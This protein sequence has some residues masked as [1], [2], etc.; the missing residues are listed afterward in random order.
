[1]PIRMVDDPQNPKRRQ[2]S[3]SRKSGG[4][5]RI[6][7]LLI[8]QLL[9]FLIKKPKLLIG[10]IVIGGALYF[11][12][13]I[14]KGGGNIAVGPDEE[15]YT[16]LSTGLNMSQEMYDKSSIYEPL[17]AGYKNKLPSRVS[18]EKYCPPRL[19]Q[20]AQGSCVGWSS[21]YAARTIQQS[22][23]TG[24]NPRQVAFSPSSLYNQIKLPNCQ[25]AYIHDAMEV[26]Y[27]RGVL[28]F[29]D[30]KYDQYDCDKTPS[31]SQ[32]TVASQYKT[33]GF[34][35]L[36]ENEGGTDILAI[37]QNIAQGAP[38][39]VGMLVGGSFMNAMQGRKMWKPTSSD[40][41]A[42]S[43]GGHAMCVMGYD[44]NMDGGAFQIMN[45]W[46]D[47]WGDQGFCWIKYTDFEHFTKEAYGLHP[48]GNAANQDPNK[49]SVDFGLVENK[50]MKNIPL[51]QVGNTVFRSNQAVNKGT[52]FKIEVTNTVECYTYVLGEET[53]GTSYV[54]FPYNEK[55]SP[56][57]GITGTRL[58]PRT[59]SLMA[60]D[61]GSRDRIA[62]V[63]SKVP[64]DAGALNKAMNSAPGTYD[65]KLS[66]VL[67]QYTVS[68][69]AFKSGSVIHF[70]AEVNEKKAVAMVI[71]L[72]KK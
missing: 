19:N 39:V 35:R 53:D 8:P 45:S 24:K 62:V 64:I 40:R 27:K 47:R 54:L 21:S 52:R 13:D 59:Q 58:F 7:L 43:F 1:M 67:G 44:D 16:E 26:M 34:E 4:L 3:N 25:G 23:A 69:V 31:S 50:T 22:V 60:D 66:A 38:V 18:L 55:H 30:F 37:K 68:N 41:R 2:Q 57:C 72:Q 70:D 9:K 17:V 65:Q 5:P 6:L 14:F 42:R 10:L 71:E 48:M 51:T 49:L 11:F 56:Y 46:G 20:G 29:N 61:L 12:T 33:K 32:M 63:I 15:N 36:W 28:P